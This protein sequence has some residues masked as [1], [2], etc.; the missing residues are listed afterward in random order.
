MTER[1]CG[2]SGSQL[3][4]INVCVNLCGVEILM[5]QHFLQGANVNAVLQH[6]SRRRVTK[7]MRRVERGVQSGPFE[8]FLHHHLNTVHADSCSSV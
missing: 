1:V 8:I 4:V 3:R 5:T 6:E 2:C 7:F